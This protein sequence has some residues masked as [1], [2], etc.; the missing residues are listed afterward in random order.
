MKSFMMIPVEF[1]VLGLIGF[2]F[3][4]IVLIGAVVKLI[5]DVA[6]LEQKLTDC[7]CNHGRMAGI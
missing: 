7:Q 5:H 1:V 4:Q 2:G 6:R 3:I